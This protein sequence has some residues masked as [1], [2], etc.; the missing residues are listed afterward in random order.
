METARGMAFALAAGLVLIVGV[1]PRAQHES[2]GGRIE[3]TGVI[4]AIDA[5]DRS[6]V[7]REARRR[8]GRFSVGGGPPVGLAGRGSGARRRSLRRWWY[9]EPPYW[10]YRANK[11]PSVVSSG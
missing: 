3:V 5:R 4:V 1:P 9:H 7:L 10:P 8:E 6:F 2:A 11:G